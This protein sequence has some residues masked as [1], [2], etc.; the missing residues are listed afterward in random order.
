MDEEQAQLID[1]VAQ[2][3]GA[4]HTPVLQRV[5]E[6]DGGDWYLREKIIKAPDKDSLTANRRVL[7]YANLLVKGGSQVTFVREGLTKTPDLKALVERTDFFLE[8]RRFRA[9]DGLVARHPVQKI[10]DAVIRKREQL[11]DTEVGLVAIDNFDLGL[12][13]EANAGFTH[14]HIVNALCELEG[15]AKDNPEGWR[16][17]SGVIVAA[18]TS[19]GA[20]TGPPSDSFGMPHFVWINPHAATPLPVDLAGWLCTSL[21]EGAIFDAGSMCAQVTVSEEE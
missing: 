17:P 1:M 3:I 13:S 19:G 12:E 11:P 5:I 18:H 7:K 2:R 6:C 8:V 9:T 20:L 14:N 15:R 10:V 21:P 4:E 16:K